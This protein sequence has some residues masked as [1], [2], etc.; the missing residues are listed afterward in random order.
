MRSFLRAALLALG[1]L[2]ATL[3]LAQ[4]TGDIVGRVTDE[5]GGALPGA[6]IEA[7]SPAFQGVRTN[8]TDATGTFRLILLPP[9]AYTVTATLPGFARVE[10]HVTV[11]LGEKKTRRILRMAA[12]MET[13]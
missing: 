2:A 9:G 11:S 7:R 8:V 1:F 3:G 5:Q 6:T 13:V 12:V 4:T 10:Q